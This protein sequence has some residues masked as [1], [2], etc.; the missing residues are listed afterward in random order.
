MSYLNINRYLDQTFAEGP[1]LRSCFWLQGCHRHCPGCCNEQMQSFDRKIII[2]SDDAV[3]LLQ[4]AR[5][6]YGIEGVTVLGGEPLLQTKGLLPLLEWSR[7]VGLSVILFTGYLWEECQA[8]IVPGAKKMLSYIDVLIDGAYHQ[9]KPDMKRN[10]V[11]S[12]NQRFVYLTSF[13]DKSIETDPRYRHL[14]EFHFCE[15]SFSLNGCPR[16][17]APVNSKSE[18]P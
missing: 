18:R 13:Y 16:T 8:D 11:G 4:Q 14:A 2:T 7:T 6:N 9:E 17:L 10:W 5:T 12:T 15:N 3:S 1:G